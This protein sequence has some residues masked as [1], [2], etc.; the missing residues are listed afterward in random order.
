MDAQQWAQFLSVV[1]LSLHMSHSWRA[2]SNFVSLTSDAG[3]RGFATVKLMFTLAASRLLFW[4][5][6]SFLPNTKVSTARNKKMR[7]VKSFR[8]CEKQTGC[9][10]TK[11]AE[12]VNVGGN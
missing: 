9:V 7:L 12:L 3:A 11:G 4:F 5:L 8:V 6:P 10:M 1:W 2:A